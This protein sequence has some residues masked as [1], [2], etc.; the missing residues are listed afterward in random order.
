MIPA[1]KHYVFQQ[2]RHYQTLTLE[3]AELKIAQKTRGMQSQDRWMM[4]KLKKQEEEL[5]DVKKEKIVERQLRVTD[6][7]QELWVS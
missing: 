3:E 6:S 7:R 1:S 2:K 5:V 4:H